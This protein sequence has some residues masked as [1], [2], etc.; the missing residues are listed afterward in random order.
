MQSVQNLYLLKRLPNITRTNYEVAPLIC[1]K[2]LGWVHDKQHS[3]CCC[4][5][6]WQLNVQEAA[7]IKK[8][9]CPVCLRQEGAKD[10]PAGE[11]Q[12]LGL[13]LEPP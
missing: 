13:E 7:K 3:K 12:G 2:K 5:P 6:L 1:L 4:L 8:Y 9:V 10:S 11:V